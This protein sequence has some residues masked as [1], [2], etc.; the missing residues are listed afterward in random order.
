VEAPAEQGYV[1]ESD[2]RRGRV[3]RGVWSLTKLVSGVAIVVCA[4]VAVAWGAHRYAITTPRF[5]V[6]N[7]EIEGNR[8]KSD[9]QVASRIGLLAGANIF[10]VDLAQAERRLLDDPWIREAK[11][12]RRLPGTLKVQIGEREPAATA[13]IGGRLY[14]VTPTGEPF[15]EVERGDPVDLPAITGMEAAELLRDRPRAVE[16]LTAAIQVLRHY[17]RLPMSQAF[18]A[19]EVHLTAG[20]DVV[21]TVG[22]QAITLHLGKGPWRKKLLMAA[23]VTDGLRR[24]GQ[25]PGIVFLDNEAHPE[26]VVVRLR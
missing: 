25:V 16:R 15:K 24:K 11:L 12:S 21:L 26:R 5:A 13:V 18:P 2:A 3:W 19:Q 23:E 8:R 20:G 7:V 17:E 9:A 1:P 6:R 10:T 4:S 14:L 22:V